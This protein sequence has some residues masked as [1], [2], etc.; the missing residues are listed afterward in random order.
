[1]AALENQS[2]LLIDLE[3]LRCPGLRFA[4]SMR[5]RGCGRCGGWLLLLLPPH[6]PTAIAAAESS[7]P[8][9]VMQAIPLPRDEVSFQREGA[10]IAR[11]YF[12]DDLNRPFLFPIMGPSGRPLTRMGHPHDPETHSHHNSVW[13]SHRDV[14]GANFWEDR[15][16]GGAPR[17]RIAHK[18]IV[19]FEDGTES[20]SVASVNAWTG[21][22]GKVL[23]QER[24]VMTAAS[25]P[26]REWLL[27]IDLQLEPE[28]EATTLGKTPFGLIGVRMAKTI[29]VNDGGGV[30]RNSAGGTNEAGCF[31]K[32]ARWVDYSGPI[33]ASAVEGISLMDH[34]G[35]PGHPAV[36]HVRN[37]GWMGISVTFDGARTIA[38]G[39]HMRLRYGLYIHGGMPSAERLNEKWTDFSRRKCPEFLSR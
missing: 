6:F 37:D 3:W 32:A 9:P 2:R 17:V 10:E 24:R 27:I 4:V 34:P 18:R 21:E 39:E 16:S 36:F 14:N 22:S 30:I 29:G 20:A 35:N 33:T 23:L 13:I 8:V 7:R 26:D 15:S 25:L 11:Y 28:K 1:M 38:A 5:L 12:G 31:W 19:A